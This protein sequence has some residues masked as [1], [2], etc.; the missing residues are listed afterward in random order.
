MILHDKF[1]Q[2][3]GERDEGGA[4]MD[5]AGVD[6]PEGRIHFLTESQDPI[7]IMQQKLPLFGQF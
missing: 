2:K 1:L 3:T 5:L 4:D 7:H 6:F